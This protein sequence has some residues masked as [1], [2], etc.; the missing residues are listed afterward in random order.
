[1]KIKFNRHPDSTELFHDFMQSMADV[2]DEIQIK[3]EY[4]KKSKQNTEAE[5]LH[6]TL[7]IIQKYFN[8]RG[9][10]PV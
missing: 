8:E 5:I 7:R 1:M 4:C 9:Q 6:Y 2:V 3:R 10:L